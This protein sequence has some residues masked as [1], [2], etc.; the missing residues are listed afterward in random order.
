MDSKTRIKILNAYLN[1][2]V[3]TIPGGENRELLVCV[4]N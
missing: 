2:N 3:M 4:R 1:N